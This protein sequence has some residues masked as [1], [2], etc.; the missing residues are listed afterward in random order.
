MRQFFKK[1]CVGLLTFALFALAG[2]GTY[3]GITNSGNGGNASSSSTSEATSQKQTF[4]A[5]LTFNGKPKYIEGLQVQWTRTD[6]IS[7]IHRA[8][9]DENG[10]ASVDGL[11]G[12]YA[13]TLVGLASNYLYNPNLT[14]TSENPSVEIKLYRKTTPTTGK[15]LDTNPYIAPDV[16]I[17]EATIKEECVKVPKNGTYYYKNAVYYQFEAKK[18][19]TYTVESW[20]EASSN[21]VNPQMDIYSGSAVYHRY[22]YAVDDG[23][24]CNTYTKNFL[25]S[26]SLDEKDFSEDGKG[27]QVVFFF[28]VR[29]E[30]IDNKYP[31]TVRFQ[32]RYTAPYSRE[33]LPSDLIAPT[34]LNQ[35]LLKDI[36]AL[37]DLAKT[38]T[39]SA[40]TAA[41]NIPA[42]EYERLKALTAE[43]RTNIHTPY[44][45]YG[46]ETLEYLK[47]KYKD[48]SAVPLEPIKYVDGV[49]YLDG[50]AVKYFDPNVLYSDGTKS[51]YG[52]GFYHYYDEETYADNF[53]FG[54][55]LYAYIT[56][57]N[58]AM[59]DNALSTVEYAGSKI[60]SVNIKDAEGNIRLLNHKLFIEGYMILTNGKA[61]SGST[62]FCM[63]ECECAHDLV[64]SAYA[65]CYPGCTTCHKNCRQCP[66][67]A[68]RTIGYADFATSGKVPVTKE[69]Q[70]FLQLLSISQRFFY[71]GNSP[72][73][74]GDGGE[75][76][77]STEDNQWLFGCVAR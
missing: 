6:G 1:A 50:D 18:P 32:I 35:I 40:F 57:G 36:C 4:T 72:L 42:D 51:T 39:Q 43:E 61:T 44:A 74:R 63:E 28:G 37:S 45:F 12:D 13:V 10:L 23:G 62:Y 29:A 59:T 49:R 33:A 70:N 58:C 27:G 75:P 56:T 76:L 22:S 52:D 24:V 17:Y 38:Q 73:E 64:E 66:E 67:E 26:Y 15:G 2:C 69:M 31:V 53:G 9:F 20:V 60:L 41:T 77:Q 65:V 54:P 8:T 71:D 30:Q 46:T 47:N 19:G 48:T 68:A 7:E 14:A 3:Q 25:H 21:T 16:G 11:D 5:A 55:Y 34:E